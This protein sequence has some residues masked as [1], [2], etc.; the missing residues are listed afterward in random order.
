M[1][2]G[3]IDPFTAVGKGWLRAS[4]RK[5]DPAQSLPYRPYHALDESQ[6]LEPGRIYELEIELWP[7]CLVVPAGYRIALTV[8]GRDYEYSGA[9]PSRLSNFKNELRGC[10]PFLHDD[11]VDRPADVF[12]GQTTVY[13]GGEHDSSLLLPVIAD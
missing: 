5:L 9:T 2:T 10:G 3:A 4:L 12:G 1:F 7:T 8:Q 13:T 11:E 6:P